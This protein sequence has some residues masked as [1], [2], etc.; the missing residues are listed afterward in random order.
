MKPQSLNLRSR[1][2]FIEHDSQNVKKRVRPVAL[3]LADVPH[4]PTLVLADEPC[5]VEQHP[6]KRGNDSIVP[7][8][9]PQSPNL[10]TRKR[11]SEPVL[12]NDK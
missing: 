7:Q 11:P 4:S 5:S 8:M 6:D 3:N 1:K 10:R 2:R 9:R 12:R